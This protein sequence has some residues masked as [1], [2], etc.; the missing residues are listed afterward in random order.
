MFAVLRVV[1]ELVKHL[2]IVRVSS[3]G[4]VGGVFEQA[5]NLLLPERVLE[6]GCDIVANLFFFK[7]AL[8]VFLSRLLNFECVQLFVLQLECEPN[9]AEM[10]PAQLLEDHVSVVKDLT[11]QNVKVGLGTYFTWQGW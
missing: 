5:A 11:I 10:A 8:S 6:V 2:Q 3:G 9:R 4:L 1:E 7:S